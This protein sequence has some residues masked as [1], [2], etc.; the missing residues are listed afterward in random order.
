MSN[1]IYELSIFKGIERD[2]VEEIVNNCSHKNFSKGVNIINEGDESNGEGYIILSGR[3]GISINKSFIAELSQ[4]DIFGEI[5][6]LNEEKRTATVKSLSNLEVIVLRFD[7]IINMINGGSSK[8][9][10][11]II[12]RIEENIGDL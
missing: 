6:L 5:A 2:V 12:R 1:N 9:N 3:V 7:D 8:I 11:E 10:K 4:G